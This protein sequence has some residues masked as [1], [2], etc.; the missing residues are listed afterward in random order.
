MP[1][2]PIFGEVVVNNKKCVIKDKKRIECKTE[3]SSASVAKVLNVYASTSIVSCSAKE[4]VVDYGGKALFYVCYEDVDGNLT[5]CEC[6]SEFIGESENV[7][8]TPDCRVTAEAEVDKTEADVSGTRLVVYANITVCVRAC[9]SERTSV[10]TGG[11]GL[12]CDAGQVNTVKSMGIRTGTY[13]LE[14]DFELSYA[15]DKVLY[16]RADARVTAAQCGVGT[17]IIDGEVFLSSVILQK[18]DK[19]YIIKE[20]RKIP[21]RMEV[22]C[23]DAMPSDTAVARIKST[24]LKTD[25]SVDEQSGKSSVLAAVNVQAE[26][27]AFSSENFPVVK[28]VFSKNEEVTTERCKLN[29]TVGSD[30]RS[31]SVRIS[32]SGGVDV[33]NG[34]PIAVCAERAE[35]TSAT[36]EETALKIVGVLSGTVLFFDEDGKIFARKVEAPFEGKIEIA[37]SENA[38]FDVVVVAENAEASLVGDGVI[39]LGADLYVSVYPTTT[40]TTEC[41]KDVKF[42]GEKKREDAAISVYI[43]LKGE[44]AWSLA[45]RLNEAPEDLVETNPELVF[46]LSGKERIVVYRQKQV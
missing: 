24:S 16:Q 28:D 39:E 7:D 34:T 31:G 22:D 5:K 9:K 2:E 14:E 1:L 35:I 15:I 4:G 13:P 33:S 45:K 44:S 3:I 43:P 10:L 37:L 32:A 26:C 8:I 46:P 40:Q 18:S 20:N 21:F 27:E 11:E 36:P 12:I 6:G 25:I 38:D 17:I 42:V 19:T 29:V 41:V 30:I 23:E